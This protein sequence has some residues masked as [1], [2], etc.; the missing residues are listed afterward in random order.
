MG[1]AEAADVPVV[2]VGD[3]D[4]GGVIASLVGTWVAARAG[5]AGAAA[6]LSSSTSSAATCACST[7]GSLSSSAHTGL[8][9]FGV[10]PWFEAARRLPAEDAVALERRDEPRP[11]RRADPRRRPAAAAHRQL[12]RSRPADGR[13]G[14]RGGVRP[15]RPRASRRHRCHRAARLEGDHRRSRRPARG[16]L[17]H[18]HRGPPAPRRPR[19]RPMRRLPDAGNGDQRSARHRRPAG[20]RARPWPARVETELGSRQ[21]AGRDDRDRAELRCAGAGIRDARR[22]HQRAGAAPADAAV[23]WPGRRER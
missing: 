5:R 1:F 3:I 18:R 12:R 20:R 13:A 7:T 4:R 9:S 10:V 8:R 19:A 23:G 16:G 14:R 22:A 11:R 17:G 21:D 15:F 2:L 6:R